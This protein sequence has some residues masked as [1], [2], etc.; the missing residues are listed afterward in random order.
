MHE[1]AK[2]HVKLN[3]QFSDE[4]SIEVASHQGAVLSPVLFIV[5][6]EVLSREF[7]VGCLWVLL[8]ADH[9]VLMAET[10]EY[11]KKKLIIWKDNIEAKRPHINI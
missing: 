7:K 9:L 6:M 2:F 11:L 4:F 10:L 3:L 8:F 1:I 5:I